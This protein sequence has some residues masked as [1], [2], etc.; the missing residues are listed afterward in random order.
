[1]VIG[2]PVGEIQVG[3]KVLLLGGEMPCRHKEQTGEEE[4]AYVQ[5]IWCGSDQISLFKRSNVGNSRRIGVRFI[6]SI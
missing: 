6:R 2:K 4:G 5:Q 3:K 1:M